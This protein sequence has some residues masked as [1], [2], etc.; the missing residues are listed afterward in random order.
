V[1]AE[2]GD[3]EVVTDN[4]DETPAAGAA[5]DADSTEGDTSTE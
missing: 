2:G 4:A 1:P 5:A 3:V